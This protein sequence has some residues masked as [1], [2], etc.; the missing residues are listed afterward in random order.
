MGQTHQAV[1][2]LLCACFF[3]VAHAVAAGSRK[4]RV[5]TAYLLLEWTIRIL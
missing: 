2:S 5:L 3:N 1:F 4:L